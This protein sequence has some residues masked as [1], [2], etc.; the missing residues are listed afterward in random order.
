MEAKL[1]G[2]YLMMNGLGLR[3]HL[4]DSINTAGYKLRV[5]PDKWHAMIVSF[6]EHYGLNPKNIPDSVLA[7]IG[8]GEVQDPCTVL[9]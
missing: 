8:E 5:D 2:T 3:T 6:Q 4:H 9:T 1:I 7:G